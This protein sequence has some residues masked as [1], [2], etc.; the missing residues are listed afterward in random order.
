MHEDYTR[1]GV[2]REQG[3]PKRGRGTLL[4][5]RDAADLDHDGHGAG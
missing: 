1:L 3:S 4:L 2:Q 5:K